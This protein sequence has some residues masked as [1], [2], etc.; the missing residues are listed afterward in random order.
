M[1]CVVFKLKN[2]DTDKCFL[3][4]C[5]IYLFSIYLNRN[6]TSKTQDFYDNISYD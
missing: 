2:I 3:P 4:V 1:L 6:K 5:L